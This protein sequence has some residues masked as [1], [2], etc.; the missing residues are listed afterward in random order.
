[1]NYTTV[2]FLLLSFSFYLFSCSPKQQEQKPSFAIAIHG[3]AGHFGEED[4]SADMQSMYRTSLNNALTAGEDLLSQGSSA[5]EVVEAVIRILEDDSLFNA[6][7][8]AVFTSEAK[9]ELDASIADGSSRNCGAVTGLNGFKHPISVARSVMDSSEHVFFSGHGAGVFAEK[10]SHEPADASWFHTH[11]AYS[12]YKKAAERS[13]DEVIPLEEKRG[14]VGCAVL[15]KHGNLAAGTSTGGMTYKKHGRI[16]D[17]PVIGAG[18]WADN[19]TCA[20]SATGWG[21]YFIRTGVTQDVHSRM[22]HGKESLTDAC[23]GAIFDEMGKLGG[24]GG[25]VA[26][27]SNGEIALVCNSNGMFRA[28][29]NSE[30]RGIA[31]FGESPDGTI[32]S[33]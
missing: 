12:R 28:W 3:G 9:H 16:G 33:H 15:D 26:V 10:F 21:E 7:R 20:V 27:S 11:K 18:T 5:V 22:L 25:V 29:S 1:M 30:N 17:S 32:E 13:G 6:G 4:I 8:G 31:M 19:R 14:T 23:E 2:S 24:D